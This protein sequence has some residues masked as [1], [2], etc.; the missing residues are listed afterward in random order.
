MSGTE[1]DLEQAIMTLVVA[2]EED[3]MTTAT[4]DRE[5]AEAAEL[6]ALA[7]EADPYGT[8][9]YLGCGDEPESD[10]TSH[11]GGA[12]LVDHLSIGLLGK[13][14]AAPLDAPMPKQ[15]TRPRIARTMPWNGDHP[16]QGMA[17]AGNSMARWKKGPPAISPFP[18]ADAARKSAT[19][20][21]VR[22]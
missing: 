8:P 6:Q 11:A 19:Y 17:R 12:G 10:Y 7:H 2:A 9:K 22:A 13:Y 18:L 21:Q 1:D 20:Q 16:A 15:F 4:R 14:L 5:L 3:A